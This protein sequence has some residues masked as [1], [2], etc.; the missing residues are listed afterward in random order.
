MLATEIEAKDQLINFNNELLETNKKLEGRTDSLREAVEKNKEL[1]GIAAH[2][3]KNPLGGIIGLADMIL[4]D[5]EAGVQAT[6]ESALEHVPLLKEEA[7]RMLVITKNLLDS[8]RHDEQVQLNKEMVLLG[9]IVAAVIRWNDVQAKS[10]NITLH[11]GTCAN[12]IVEVDEIAIQ[13]V[14]DNYV[15]NAVKYSPIGTNVYIDVCTSQ[16]VADVLGNPRV[17]V[18]VRD[19]GPGLTAADKLKVFGKM[20]RLSAKPTGGEHSTGLG[21]FIVK[22]LIEAHSGEVGVDS[23]VGEGAVFWFTL[24]CL[25]M[26]GFDVPEWPPAMS[27]ETEPA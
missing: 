2:D 18:S 13:R 11:Y 15:S 6:Y 23:E 17:K 14:L 9:D 20:Q 19:E 16:A 24:P 12:I 26:S 8:Q 21:L 22:S 3:L 25:A 7:E 1:L 27:P 10:K 5:M 4:E